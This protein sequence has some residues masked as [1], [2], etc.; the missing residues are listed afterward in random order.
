M[1]DT[2]E[3]TGNYLPKDLRITAQPDAVD[4]DKFKVVATGLKISEAYVF[5][6]QY[7]FEDGKT[8]EWSPSYS[9]L[10][11]SESVPSAPSATVPST[12]TGN[13]PVTL[14]AF[15]ANAK[16]V[17]IYVI[18]GI[19]GSGK[20]VDSFLAAGTKTISISDPGV[21]Q[22]ALI[23]V[24][25][26]GIN[27]DPT[28]T[29]TITVSASTVDT[30][31]IPGA[32]SSV[33]VA[34]FNDTSDPLNRTGYAN[35]NWTAG[36]GAK[37]YWVGLWTNTPGSTDP[38]RQIETNGTSVRVDGLAVGSSYYIQVKSYNTF[39]NPS[40]W[41]APSSNYPV[42]IP[43]NTTVPGAV[44]ISGS[45]TP[46]SIV[47]SW[48]E[49]STAANLV[50]SGGYYVAKLYTNAAG[51][52]TPLETRTCFSNSAT[53]AGLTTGTSYYVTVQP[54][55]AGASPVAGT[56]SNV[57][58]PLIPTAVEPPDIQADFILA[59]NQFQVGGTSG[60]NDIHLSAYTKTVGG[61]STKGR[62]YIG[63]PETSSSDAVGLY[64]SSGTPFYADNLGRFSLGD[65]LT[66]SGSALNVKGTI[67]V[68]GAST[69][70]SYLIAGATNSTFIGIG[71]QVPYRLS[72]VL[73]T[74]ANA[75][76]GIVLNSSGSVENSDWIKSDGTFRLANGAL[77]FSGGLL[78]A[79]GTIS[80]TSL[81]AN[82]SI[83][84]PLIT[85]GTYRTSIAVGNGSTAGIKIDTSGIYGY[86][87]SSSTP[88]FS[89]SNT[90]V[91]TASSGTIGGWTM[92]LTQLRSDYVVTSGTINSG[93]GN[94]ITLN[95]ATPRITLTQGATLTNGIPTGGSSITIDPSSGI[96]G[97]SKVVQGETRTSFSLD[98]AGNV[99]LAGSIFSDSGK[100]A[101]WTISSSTITSGGTTL[102]SSGAISLTG[103][104][105][106]SGGTT[107]TAGNL[108]L[109][110]G[111]ITNNQTMFMAAQGF[112]FDQQ[113]SPSHP[114]WSW[115][116]WQ[117][118]T[119]YYAFTSRVTYNGEKYLCVISN[120]SSGPAPTY[121]NP[122]YP[123]TAKSG[124]DYYWV[125][126]G[127]SYFSL[128][129]FNQVHLGDRGTYFTDLGSSR[130]ALSFRIY[131]VNIGDGYFSRGYIMTALD[132]SEFRA[133]TMKSGS[134]SGM[135]YKTVVVGYYGQLYNGRALYYGAQSSSSTINNEVGGDIGDIY[136]SSN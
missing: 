7:V 33:T 90:G 35:V 100:I 29:F 126:E 130:N 77:K 78:E 76:N 54:Y 20:V 23:A 48:T 17:D 85:G 129:S 9:L 91:M 87:A 89:V 94:Y 103:S 52:G 98:P 65:K 46:R 74:G 1:A 123:P 75:I 71:Y 40:A 131:P 11:S 134:N 21:Y 24:S 42:L 104:T 22:V 60:A 4:K 136:F 49:P 51:S 124:S 109:Q 57:F 50:T 61:Q 47:V 67:D 120:L 45:G 107:I 14:L 28:N 119:Q 125:E 105:F 66:W 99:S 2:L 64:N 110:S 97:P 63:G 93:I 83:E 12:S 112:S 95:P 44:T 115:P 116:T 73:Q 55:T 127:N 96:V 84:S 18:G 34:G 92:N 72:S 3:S 26:S 53:F 80:A 111:G 122:I 16:R 13:I 56:L 113:F 128:S 43:G 108:T 58:G 36:S 31:V 69:F 59:N 62:I 30:T 19:Y 106:S 70:S 38:I 37:G 102:N 81:A 79:T 32:P 88:N 27:G 118:N 5:Q 82:A 39:N 114:D 86:T 10:T 132:N 41:V 117:L 68:T 133:T 25:P 101:G 6:F 135:G 8:S 15:P 121:S